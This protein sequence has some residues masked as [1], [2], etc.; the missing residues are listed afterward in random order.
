MLYFE[1][2][3]PLYYHVSLDEKM[4]GQVTAKLFECRISSFSPPLYV[5][6]TKDIVHSRTRQLTLKKVDE[7]TVN[8]LFSSDERKYILA[9]VRDPRISSWSDM[10]KYMYETE[11]SLTEKMSTVSEYIDKTYPSRKWD[12]LV[13]NILSF[14]ASKD[15]DLL[16]VFKATLPRGFVMK[17]MPH[18]L[19]ITPSSCGKT[20]YYDKVGKRIDKLTRQTLLGSVRWVDDKSAGL[21]HEQHYPLVV[22]QIESQQVE[23]ITG[24]LLSFL[25]LGRATVS[26][27]GAEMEVRGACSF[28]ITSNPMQ[29]DARKDVVLETILSLLSKNVI[30]LGRRFGIIA[31]NSYQPVKATEYDDVGHSQVIQFYRSVEE[32]CNKTLECLW[33]DKR[34]IEYCYTKIDYSEIWDMIGSCEREG[35]KGFLKT[36]VSHGYPH[37]RGGS[38]N[39]AIV[40][41]LPRILLHELTGVVDFDTIVQEVIQR[42]QSYCDSLRKVNV[43]SIR[44]ALK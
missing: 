2:I 22:E 9:V 11:Y 17:F 12:E 13:Q 4:F 23:N 34:V 31:Y 39:M 29:S 40:D 28:I 15:P 44:Y 26:G 8:E 3:R 25:E 27:G 14:N 18:T 7:R 19:M 42:A 35:V 37:T 10:L 16:K 36:F 38:V 20:E 6:D 24:F 32:R 5:L 33:N 1:Y 43:D 41:Y 21:F 30:A